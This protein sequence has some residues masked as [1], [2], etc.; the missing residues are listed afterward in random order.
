VL[1]QTEDG[2][3]GHH[4]G[5][6][7]IDASPEAPVTT[8]ANHTCAMRFVEMPFSVI[9]NVF[10]MRGRSDLC[11]TRYLFYATR[12]RVS[13]TDYKGHHPEWRSGYVP[14][15]PLAQ[16]A[17]ITAVLSA[18][19]DLI[20]NNNRRIKILEEM[21]QRIYREWFVDFRYPGH[22]GVPLVDSEHGPI[23]SGWEFRPIAELSTVTMGQSPPSAAYN[24][25]GDGLPFH[26]GVGSY[27]PHF[28]VHETFS[29]EGSR[30]AEEG[31]ILVSVR[32]P[33]GR[34]NAADRRLILGR[35]LCAIRGVEAPR[36]FIHSALRH[37]F[38]VEDVIGNGAIFNSVKRRDMEAVPVL[39]PGELIAARVASILQ[40][41]ASLLRTLTYQIRA[42]REARDLLLPRLVSGEIDVTDLDIAMPEA[43]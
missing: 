9:Q 21:A 38:A 18:Y 19:D 27:G 8:F 20:E 39:W 12:G 11:T 41:L 26:Q 2:V 30:I 16:Q 6:P 37:F 13:S 24:Q 17:K 23:P 33:V 22:E 32:A 42:L 25:S 4:N 28:P 35:G 29:T 36:E 3:L 31:D 7:G 34:I 10:P 15:P 14:L 1:D 43:V 40:P 5:E